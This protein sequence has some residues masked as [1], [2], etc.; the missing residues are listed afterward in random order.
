[1]NWLYWRIEWPQALILIA[2]LWY[3]VFTMTDDDRPRRKFTP[4][5]QSA[6]AVSDTE[7]PR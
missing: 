1:M 5:L 3:L 7:R 2:Y 6:T 4:D